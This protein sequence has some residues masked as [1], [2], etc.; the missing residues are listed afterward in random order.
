MINDST[1]ILEIKSSLKRMSVNFS[2]KFYN[3]IKLKYINYKS[4]SL[5]FQT[6]FFLLL[7][8]SSTREKRVT[9]EKNFTKKF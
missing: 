2:T 5:F 9:E 7:T 3:K 6:N 1:L 8:S 4:F